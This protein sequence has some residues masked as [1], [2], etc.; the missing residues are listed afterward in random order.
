VIN[1]LAVNAFKEYVETSVTNDELLEI[2]GV[3]AASIKVK[4]MKT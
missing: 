2:L 3:K 1:P 4:R